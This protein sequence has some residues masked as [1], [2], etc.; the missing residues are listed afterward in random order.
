MSG[1][2]PSQAERLNTIASW[3]LGPRAENIEYL[4]SF[5]KKALEGQKAG[6]E[7]YFPNDPVAITAEIQASEHFKGE[8]GHSIKTLS[9]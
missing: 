1:R 4:Q 2:E 5:F 6:R 8:G 3:F 9:R 7:G